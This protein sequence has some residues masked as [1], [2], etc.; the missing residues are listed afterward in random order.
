M[1]SA[2]R[3]VGMTLTLVDF[4]CGAGVSSQDAVAVPR[5][6]V[7]LAANHWARAIASYAA[8]FPAAEHFRGAIHDA[9]VARF[10][11]GELF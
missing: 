3:Q 7:R 1:G 11:S 8:N 4:F 9:D 10:P 6:S 2:G 5:V